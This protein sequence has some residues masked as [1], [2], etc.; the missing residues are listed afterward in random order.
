MARRVIIYA[1]PYIRKS[2]HLEITQGSLQ[3]GM[4]GSNSEAQERF[5]DG[6]NSNIVVQYYY[7]SLLNYCKGVHGLIK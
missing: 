1:V 4:P 2:L 3:S 7:P 5:C 6:L